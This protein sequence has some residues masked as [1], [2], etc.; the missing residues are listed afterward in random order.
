MHAKGLPPLTLALL[1]AFIPLSAQAGRALTPEDWYRFQAVSDLRVAA[2]GTAVAYLVTSY[3]KGSDESRA[4]LW[5]ADWSGSHG[6]P[7]TH[8][9][10]VSAPRFSPDGRSISF[11]CARPEGEP[12]QL[13]LMD[14]HG[15][16]PRQLTHVHREITG[17]EWAPDG[18]HIVLVMRGPE[19]TGAEGKPP[20]AGRART[21]HKGENAVKP[22]VIDA[23]QFKEDQDGYLTTES[24]SHLYL[25]DVHSGAIEPLT[26]DVE[27]ADSHPVF[28]PDGRQI[29]YVSRRPGGG[30]E[31]AGV[32][33]IYLIPAAAGAKPR[34]LLKTWTPNRQHLEW[35][36]DGRQIAF[37]IGDEPKYNAYILDDLAV[38][39]VSSGKVRDLTSKL[40]R[41][42]L[43]PA[44]AS[45]GRSI[46]FAVEDDG[47]QYPAQVALTS[48]A[49]TH[50]AESMVVSELQTS[51]GHTAVLASSDESA[52]EVYALEAGKLR[53]LSSHNRALLDELAL[54][55]VENI[56]FSSRDGT[57]IHG[58]LVK[59]PDF[60][61]GH[62]YPTI[63]WIHGGP[64]GQD[65]H[66]L[67]L[68]GYG[69]PLERQLFATHGYVVLAVNYRGS[70]G[71]GAA[72]AR[73]ILADWG[74]KEVED[75][76]AGVDHAVGRGI[77]DP[78]HLGIG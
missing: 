39:E 6:E 28:S 42:V 78:A 59:P 77:A 66:E 48:G 15:G 8:G 73:S 30:A 35:S 16:Q 22:I 51:A 41:A 17:Y 45:D 53:P 50:L 7:L 27:R 9:E 5:T 76:L 13:W 60:V 12:T 61:I 32:D 52:T 26:S 55:S 2:D 25:L 20:K 69:P 29:A 3:D 31:D 54:G 14:R 23:Y 18:A 11:L 49:I 34:R 62:R 21:V 64:N 70:T 71:R 57:E 40:D 10:S 63:L 19:E 46:Q 33:E 74:H 37:L 4:A 67:V 58:Q 65:Q 43:S 44:F 56:V 24:R 36:P 38:V 47:Y 75:L 72:F 1:I 68:E